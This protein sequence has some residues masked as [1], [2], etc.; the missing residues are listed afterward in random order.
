MW[1]DSNPLN[2]AGIPTVVY[3]PGMSTAGGKFA[4]DIDALVDAARVYALTAM[5]VCEVVD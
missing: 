1:R 5:E 3:G 4:I 2:E